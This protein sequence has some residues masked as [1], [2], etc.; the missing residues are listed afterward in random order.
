MNFLSCTS[1]HNLYCF[2]DDE[3]IKQISLY[4]KLYLVSPTSGW[5]LFKIEVCP[6]KLIMPFA[7]SFDTPLALLLALPSGM[8][9]TLP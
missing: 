9:M 1:P 3:N 5:W 6:L 4:R 8:P 7:M 2:S